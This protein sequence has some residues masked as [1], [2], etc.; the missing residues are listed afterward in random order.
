MQAAIL[1]QF[2]QSLVLLENIEIPK[3]KDGQLLVKLEYAGVCQSQLMEVRGK[4]GKN[5]YL[6]H[7]LGH[8]GSGTVI[9]IGQKVKKVKIDDQVILGWI[10]GSGLDEGGISYYHKKLGK[11]NAGAVT[12]FNNYAVVSENRCTLLPNGLPLD[13]AA[14]FGCAIPTGA[15]I[16]LNE[17]EIKENSILAFWGLGGIGMSAFITSLVFPCRQ[18]IVIDVSQ[19]KLNFAKNLGADVVFANSNDP[20]SE[21]VDLTSGLGVDY[22]IESAGFTKTIEQAFAILN[23]KHGTCIFAS[24]PQYGDQISLDPF[25]LICGKKIVGTNGGGCFPDHDIPKL[26]KFYEK[27]S[28]IFQRFIS[29]YYTLDQINQALD[30]LENHR[31]FRPIIKF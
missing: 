17:L 23:K 27:K 29:Q 24:H 28:S 7:L 8:E 15:G 26:A 18:R 11:V 9:D 4:R 1:Q 12:T 13:I 25:E 16:I 31:V 10:K 19:E 6:P 21:V 2:N 5:K 3:L 30:D 20:V 22:A 14:L